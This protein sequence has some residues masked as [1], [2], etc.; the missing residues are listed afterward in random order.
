MNLEAVA[1][2]LVT[3]LATEEAGP[4]AVD[5]TALKSEAVAKAAEAKAAE[6]KAAE[7]NAEAKAAADKDNVKSQH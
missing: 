7:A 2:P 4:P 1:S 3:P 5:T 6:A